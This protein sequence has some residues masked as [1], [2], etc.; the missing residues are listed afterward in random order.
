MNA[1]GSVHKWRR[2]G[3]EVRIA[4]LAAEEA[5][6]R[7]AESLAAC[8]HL[9]VDRVYALGGEDKSLHHSVH[10]LIEPV[11]SILRAHE[12]DTVVTHFHAD[13]HQDHVSAYKIVAAAARK[14]PNLLMFKPTYPSGRTQIPFQPNVVSMLSAEDIE[15]KVQALDAFRSQ[16]GKYGAENWGKAMHAVA[17]GD[18]WTYAGVHG[19]AEIFQLGLIRI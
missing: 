7:H 16:R 15:A 17:Q 9:D 13:T 5:N 10:T 4:I 2:Q 11:E 3:R 8:M 18:A 1:G 12:V 14:V 19:Y 6:V